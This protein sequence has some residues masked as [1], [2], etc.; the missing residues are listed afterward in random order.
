M[1]RMDKIV[2]SQKQWKAVGTSGHGE[3]WTVH[4]SLIIHASFQKLIY[5]YV[6]FSYFHVLQLFFAPQLGA[7]LKW[8][9]HWVC[10][11]SFVPPSLILMWS[12]SNP[13]SWT[14]IIH[15]ILIS[16]PCS[17]LC[18]LSLFMSLFYSFPQILHFLLFISFLIS[19]RDNEEASKSGFVVIVMQSYKF[20]WWRHVRMKIQE[21]GVALMHIA[22]TTWQTYSR[23]NQQSI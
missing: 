14:I 10:H 12:P 20:S 13:G 15:Q 23:N 22:T 17:P 5:F 2:D 9:F 7:A 16:G 11:I 21:H 1:S 8:F 6:C 3:T 4:T 19:F 18:S